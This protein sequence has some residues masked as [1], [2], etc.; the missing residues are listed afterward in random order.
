MPGIDIKLEVHRGGT[1]QERLDRLE[2]LVRFL[3]TAIRIPG[4][5]I[6]FG[7]D[8]IVGL[9]PGLGDLVGGLL[10]A[11]VISEGI[12]SGVPRPVLVRMFWNVAVDVAL[13]AVPGVGDAFDLFWKAGVRNLALLRR[14]HDQPDRTADAS[15][16]GLL[17][18]A[19]GVGLL[20]AAGMALAVASTVF[21]VRWLLGG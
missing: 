5:R 11:L 7:A 4:T 10:A 2:T 18:L 19:A 1:A 12:R 8:A 13:G 21:L 20:A 9:V 16:R 3:E 6:R 15:R 17:A 14:Y